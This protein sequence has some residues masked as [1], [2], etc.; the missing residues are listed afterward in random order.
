MPELPYSK[1][2]PS[3][4]PRT[5]PVEAP[6]YAELQVTSNFSFLRGGSHPEELVTQAHGLGLKAIAL[7]DRSTFAGIVR[8]HTTAKE[9]GLQFI[10][11][12]ELSLTAPC[13]I[14]PSI[15]SPTRT[16][17]EFSILV[18]P[19]SRK[20]YGALCS[21]LTLGNRRTEKG[22]C[23]LTLDDYLE[24]R[25]EW[26]TILVPPLPPHGIPDHSR[27]LN[28]VA[29]AKELCSSQS[30][31]SLSIALTRD[32]SYCNHHH[33]E[34]IQEA[35]RYLDVPLVITG[36]VYYHTAARRPLQDVLTCIREKC[37]VQ[38]A[39]F[40]LAHNAERHLK[41]PVEVWRRYRDLPRA[42]RRTVE[43]AERTRDFSLDQLRYEYPDEICP[44]GQ[45]ALA[46]L[47]ALT[48]QGA[49][50]RYPHG[51]PEKVTKLLHDE[52][53]LIHELKY[54]KYFLTC[55]DIVTFA[56]SRGILCQ[57]R[58][59]AANSAVCYCLGITAVNPDKIDL[60]FA[61]FVSKERNEPPDIDIDFEH[62]RR[63]EVIQYIY[64]K[65]GRHRAGL[66]CEVVS[67]RYRSAV[68]EVGKALGLSLEVV[69][70][71]AKSI[72]RWTKSHVTEADLREI[73]VHGD[74]VVIQN[75]FILAYELLGFPRHLSQHVGGFI[76][77]AEPLS[78]TVPI[79][80]AS[81][82]NR[83]IIE[84][85]KDD[86]EALG[87]LK[88][89]VLGLGML[90]CIRK[91]L[92]LINHRLLHARDSR[93]P[94]QLHTIPAEDR[95]V[96][97]MVCNADTVGVFQ[98][99]SRAQMS[100]LPRL[101]PRCFYDLV[102]EV[103][104]VRPG[105]VH[106]NMV[107]PYLKRRNGIEKIEFPD[108][109]VKE[110]LGKTL[111][112]P[113]FQEQAM[114]LA[115][116]LAQFTPD[117]AERLRRAMAAWKRDKGVIATFKKRVV[118][119][120]R[121]NGYSEEFAETCM[122]QIKGFSEYGF[123]ESHAAS[124]AL[125]VYASAWIKK[126]FPAEFAAALLNSQPMGFYAPSQILQDA[127]AH[128][129]EILPIDVNKSAWL[130]TVPEGALALRVGM[131]LVRGL[132]EEQAEIITSIVQSYGEQVSVYDLWIHAQHRKG[133]PLRKASLELLAR[134]DAFRSMHCNQREALWEIKALPET[135]RA[136]DSYDEEAKRP[137]AG[138][139]Q[140]PLLT[141]QQ[142]MFQDYRAT[143]FSLKGHPIG[144]IR[145]YLNKRGASTTAALRVRPL[146]TSH[147]TFVRVAGIGIVRQ[148]PG[149][150]KGVVFISL[151]DETG[152]SNL[153]IRPE[154]F[155][156]YQ[157]EILSGTCLLAYGSLERVGEV[158][159]IAALALESLDKEVLALEKVPL[160]SK[161]YSY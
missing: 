31:D 12:C 159:Y 142:S 123:P 151:E 35:A 131:H 42:I 108:T 109:R 64:Q 57:G 86:I 101:K 132:S 125:L 59:A 21:L 96:Y 87:M 105:P 143:G 1:F 141:P 93:Y 113:I 99:E 9:V 11:G 34:Q 134:A 144:F 150:A 71:L 147:K 54:E 102:I 37:T 139:V 56:R 118:A 20:A 140:L 14:P 10:V 70:K 104:I 76:I 18:Y 121:A 3:L 154:I 43:I 156:R 41:S 133:P 60:L 78:E 27:D 80:N 89:D 127:A 19:T 120:M 28:F 137:G 7:T 4:E 119:G 106:G 84:W 145:P 53:Q 128:G 32:Y 17:E 67:Y 74:S 33:G 23:Q 161:S 29:F 50:E 122:N 116:V 115:I 73:G 77:S 160:P 47:Q 5:P 135:V 46:H 136:L 24:Y 149:T 157:R 111:G 114:R 68:R 39:G 153:V 82:E 117:E 129:V 15:P 148:R 112:V 85:D 45:S 97:D 146:S 13:I 26:V 51:I 65:Y 100:M 49:K 40:R 44:P 103:A 8:A 107:H 25:H 91:A 2:R 75:T 158:V 130:T 69:D 90:S 138:G 52:F 79:L 94:L 124:F 81:M 155:E 6:P 16:T 88:I 22:L 30:K 72:H 66:T 61:R 95:E 110:I 92:E 152:I 58:G 48:W 62:E 126:H 98:I 63:E 38:E 83:T 55:H 36:N